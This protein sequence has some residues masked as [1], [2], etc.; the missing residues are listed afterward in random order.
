MCI[1]RNMVNDFIRSAAT[2]SGAG[3]FE[4]IETAVRLAQNLGTNSRQK[5]YRYDLVPIQFFQCL[6]EIGVLDGS[7]IPNHGI[8]VGAAKM[9]LVAAGLRER[10]PKNLFL[11]FKLYLQSGSQE[12]LWRRGEEMARLYCIK[13]LS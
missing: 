3:C 5:F 4:G 13:R 12:H 11:D 7:Q 2:K 1:C 6:Q 8:T 9:L 10:L